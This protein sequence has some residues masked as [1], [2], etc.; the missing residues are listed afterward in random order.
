MTTQSR[1]SAFIVELRQRRVFRVAAFYGGIAFV[2]VQIID[3]TFDLMGAP[4]W[5]GRVI[6]VLLLIG[7][8]VSMIL[9]WVFDITPEGIVRTEGRSTGKPGTSNKALVAVT[10]IAVAFGIWGR[11]GGQGRSPGQIRSI[12]VL[13]LTN[14]MND[15]NLDYFVDGMHEAL[16]TELSKIGALRVISRTSAMRYRQTDKTASQIARELDV[17]ALVEGSVLLAGGRVRIT[18]Q[19][20]G[21]APER[22]LWSDNYERDMGDILALHSDVARAIAEQI[23]ATMTPE[24]IGRLTTTRQVNPEAYTAYL[25]GH[26]ILWERLDNQTASPLLET[27]IALDPDYAP[28]YA[29]LAFAYIGKWARGYIPFDQAIPRAQ[30]SIDRAISLDSQLP[31][32]YITLGLVRTVQARWQQAGEAYLQAIAIA[33]NSREAN[34]EYGW[35]LLRTG[36][37]DQAVG[38]MELGLQLDPVSV[39]SHHSLARALY[40]QR[41]YDQALEVITRGLKLDPATPGLME[42]EGLVYLQT[43]RYEEITEIFDGWA[44]VPSFLQGLIHVARGQRGQALQLIDDLKSLGSGE[45]SVYDDYAVIMIYAAL[46]DLDRAMD[47]LEHVYSIEKQRLRLLDSGII[48]LK[49]E[50]AYDPL[51]G[52][53]RFEALVKNLYSE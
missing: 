13:P 7:F 44:Q 38:Y 31:L 34:V 50:P 30:E 22:H 8:P 5:V 39:H 18:A 23:K 16:I 37:V 49:V 33:P 12:A 21:I 35:F 53:P 41:R 46:G 14:M 52:H 3:G 27:A 24:E 25:Q 6:V 17:D 43:G 36:K 11:W 42:T 9:A 47:Q 40:S 10:I 20:I 45:K 1:F 28:P 15:K 19:L 32:A 4:E 29:D 2:I 48:Y 26:H 51:R